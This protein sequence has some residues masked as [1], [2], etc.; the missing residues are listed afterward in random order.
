M[1]YLVHYGSHCRTYGPL[2]TYWSF[3]FEGKHGYFK[4]IASRLKCRKNILLTLARKHQFYHSWHLHRNDTYLHDR[5]ISNCSGKVVELNSLPFSLQEIIQPLV[6]TVRTIFQASSVEVDGVKYEP[7]LAVVTGVENFVLTL[8]LI[9]ALFISDGKLFLVGNTLQE[10]SYCRHFHCYVG[11]FLDSCMEM[12]TLRD[13]VD[14]FPLS[15]YDSKD[16]VSSVV[17]KHHIC[18]C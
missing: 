13:L 7:G 14:P 9:R 12:C 8:M 15:V 6:T 1:H 4:D 16:N 18:V 3:R 2:I 17:L 11:T 10:Q 5:S